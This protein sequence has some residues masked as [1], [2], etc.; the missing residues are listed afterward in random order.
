MVSIKIQQKCNLSRVLLYASN[1]F[2]VSHL[3]IQPYALF[4]GGGGGEKEMNVSTQKCEI[5]GPR[6]HCLGHLKSLCSYW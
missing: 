2:L 1:S 5:T 3:L 6:E 4:P